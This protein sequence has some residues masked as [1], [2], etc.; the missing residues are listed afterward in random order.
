MILEGLLT[1]NVSRYLSQSI[2]REY[3]TSWTLMCSSISCVPTAFLTS[4]CWIRSFLTGRT[5]TVVLPDGSTLTPLSRS[6]GVPQGSVLG[7]LLFSLF[8]NDLPSALQF[9]KCHLY[10]NDFVIYCSGSFK[11]INSIIEKINLDLANVSHWTSDNGLAVNASKTQAMWIGS[12]G[13]ETKV[14]ILSTPPVLLDGNVIHLSDSLKVLGITI[15]N[16]LT[17]RD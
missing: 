6:S 15:G 17:W 9:C 14:N 16:S 1:L 3:L 10:A 12:R 7:P 8:I 5:Q 2:F 13:Y 11:D 4:C